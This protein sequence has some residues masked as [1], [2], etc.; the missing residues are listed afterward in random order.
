MRDLEGLGVFY[1]GR[2]YD[3]EAGAL[4]P[5]PLLYDSADLTTHAVCLGMTGSGKTGLCATLLEEAALDGVP[6]LIID[7][8]GDMGNLL[9]AFP[10]LRAEDFAPWVDP[11]EA[12]RAGQEPAEHAAAT[13]QRWREG[14]ALW[15]QDG[16]RVRR[17][18]Q[19]AEWCIYTP[20][21]TAGRPL[22]VFR[23][24]QAPPAA[25][26]DDDDG[27]QDRVRT[28]AAGVLSLV[29]VQADP[30]RS[31]EHILLANVLERAWRAGEDLDLPELIRRVRTPP[32]EQL[33]VLELE[34]FYPKRARFEL[35]MQLNNLLASP[36]FA[37]WLTGEPLQVDTLLH[38]PAGRPRV[39]I[40]SIAHLSDAERMFFVT[41]LL[42]EVVGWMRT[43]PGTSSL[44]ALLYMDEVFGFLPPTAMPPSKR[45]LLTLLKQARSVGLG[46]VLA[47]QN[48]VDLD[49]KA[50]SNAGTWFLGRLQTERDQAR[51]LDGLLGST[52]GH[53]AAMDRSTLER[54]LAGLRKRVFLMHNVHEPP[55]VAFHS[56][57][58]LTY[59]RGPLTRAQ[60]RRL[61]P[62]VEP[63]AEPRSTAAAGP[64][65]PG[66]QAPIPP[67]GPAPSPLTQPP[68]RVPAG[69]TPDSHLQAPSPPALDPEV[70]IC[71]LP[72]RLPLPAGQRLTYRPA[73][74]AVARVHFVRSRLD[75][76][77]WQALTLLL[78]LPTAE[79][80]G[81]DWSR[82]VTLEG[83]PPDLDSAPAQQAEHAALVGPARRARRYSA[84]RKALASHLY[85]TRRI[86][87]WRCPLT[88]LVSTPAETEREFRARAGQRLHEL[89]DEHLA[90]LRQR[91]GPKLQRARDQLAKAHDALQREQ[92][93]LGQRTTDAFVSA[94]GALI[95]AFLGRKLV[96]QGKLSR[97]QRAV[98]SAGKVSGERGDVARA[99]ERV[100]AA[101]ERVAALEAELRA[102]LQ[103]LRNQTDPASM[104]VEA[105][106]NSPRRA[107]V[108]VALLSVGWVPWALGGD[109]PARPVCAWG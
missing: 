80:P 7:P 79:D 109:P 12:R 50:L 41:T 5:E 10:D 30:L 92:E 105:I 96:T 40:F 99:H 74:L 58:A 91:H 71:Y 47:T 73:L 82:A 55:P 6:S 25:L 101:Q 69:R 27:L 104:T 32:F 67:T 44:R 56:R 22:S 15:G 33:G 66:L 76:D 34:A 85:R 9:L 18:Q 60:I 77:V 2:G 102:K 20:G 64:L 4:R 21:S 89:R 39:S 43:Q 53:G 19:A 72:A 83:E 97:V 65:G 103:E 63:L 48:P 61:T 100:Q 1:L 14:L 59:L 49:Y 24:L 38:T 36:G 84:W 28:A 95:G 26:L 57:W 81:P 13:A 90:T 42:N 98:R 106:S 51:V 46:V 75:L 68:A 37:T 23:S 93:Q 78:P 45:P 107:D 70:P 17:L 62:P 87:L 16:E 31:R 86:T 11:A 8:K 94:G 3:L 88:K 52:A 108:E 29:G 35:A 54:S